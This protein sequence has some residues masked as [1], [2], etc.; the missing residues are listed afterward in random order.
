M[1]AR[2]R[3]TMIVVDAEQFHLPP[4]GPTGPLPPYVNYGAPESNRILRGRYWVQTPGGRGVL[5]D[6]DWIVT[7]KGQR[8]VLSDAVFR[9][10]YEPVPHA[11]TNDDDDYGVAV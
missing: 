5:D 11:D 6:G 3:V 9:R 1:M 2:Y 7:A 8:V 10:E 4:D